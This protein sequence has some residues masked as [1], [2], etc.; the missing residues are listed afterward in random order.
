MHCYFLH[1]VIKKFLFVNNYKIENLIENMTLL[2]YQLLYT[3]SGQNIR[4]TLLHNINMGM[5]LV[6]VLC[7]RVF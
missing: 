7:L 2:L 4:N 5:D 3:L 6:I 1:T